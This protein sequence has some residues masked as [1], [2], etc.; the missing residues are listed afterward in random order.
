[1]IAEPTVA[2]IA[3]SVRIT[4]ALCWQENHSKQYGG[5]RGGNF[6]ASKFISSFSQSINFE[7]PLALH[8]AA[9]QKVAFSV[10]SDNDH[11]QFLCCGI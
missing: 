5:R 8:L 4:H 6:A 9:I 2:Y 10:A 3:D 1:M 11:T 7:I